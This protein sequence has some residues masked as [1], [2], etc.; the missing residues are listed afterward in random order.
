LSRIDARDPGRVPSP[1]E[2]GKNLDR[3]PGLVG[4][5][6]HCV[7]AIPYVCAAPPGIRTFLDLPLV[8]GRAAPTA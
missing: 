2:L 1:P 3:L 6:M 5:A 8:C 4:T 7:N